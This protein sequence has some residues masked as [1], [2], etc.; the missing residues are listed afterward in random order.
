MS[1]LIVIIFGIG[2]RMQQVI[3]RY[4]LGMAMYPAEFQPQA[5]G[6]LIRIGAAFD[7]GYVAPARILQQSEGL[8]SFG[9][10]DEWQFE[11]TFFAAC[12]KPVICFDHSVDNKFWIK[13]FA[14]NLV[15]SI[16]Y[17][18]LSRL[19][20][21]FRFFEYRKF[22]N[23]KMCAHV[24]R[25]LG[26]GNNG[27]VSLLD[28]LNI[29]GL[30]FNVLIKMDIEGWEYRAL[31]D[32]VA[33]QDKFTGLVIEFHDIDIHYERIISFIRDVSDTLMLVHFHANSHTVFGPGGQSIVVE[34][35]FMNRNL[36][37]TGEKLVCRRLPIPG[38]DAPNLQGEREAP[39]S[40][41]AAPTPVAALDGDNRWAY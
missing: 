6:D 30:S 15:N 20:R 40:F 26:Y 21:A 32:I 12:G 29:S 34:M 23:A 13:C 18:D 5:T 41:A 33:H 3:P 38:L 37:V 14:A 24:K 17:A 9:L 27:S 10:S 35:S 16:A 19:R 11:A 28:A 4:Q 7:G 8:L 31:K 25:P 1:V 36:L 39:V 22:F 2:E